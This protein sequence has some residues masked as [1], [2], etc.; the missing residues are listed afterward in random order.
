MLCGLGG[1]RHTNVKYME[2]EEH[3]GILKRDVFC[4]RMSSLGIVTMYQVIFGKQPENL[5]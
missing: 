4:I 5:S 3:Q 2:V 1:C